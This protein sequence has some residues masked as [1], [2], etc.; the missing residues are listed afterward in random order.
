MRA[1]WNKG[2]TKETSKSLRQ[3]S[4]TMKQRKIDNFAR[5]RDVQI[6]SGKI[7]SNYKSFE[8]DG[9]L[10]ELIG[11][12]L[13]DGNLSIFPRT[14]RLLIFSNSNNKGFIN[15]YARLVE[16][17]FEKR[18][19]V[20]NLVTSKCTRISIYEK[21][22]CKRLGMSSGSKSKKHFTVPRWILKE[23]NFVL[24][25]LRGLY[26]AE[27]NFSM[28]KPTCTYKMFFS[29]SNIS[30][31]RIVYRLVKGLGF[32]PNL[33]GQKVQISRKKEVYD[34]IRLISFRKY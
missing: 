3:T 5:W 25:Y 4:L 20:K 1:P 31:E 15:R 34:F 6:E 16:K 22:I 17:I 14:E 24:R 33:S 32:H 28:H 19:A 10:A 23:R 8:K 27:G 2:L 11:V 13:G 26:E 30:L 9:D 29:N 7:K 18:P 21:H 12:I